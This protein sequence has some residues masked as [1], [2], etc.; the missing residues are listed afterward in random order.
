MEITPAE[1]AETSNIVHESINEAVEKALK[2]EREKEVPDSFFDMFL[3]QATRDKILIDYQHS[4]KSKWIKVKP[5]KGSVKECDY[6]EISF[7][8]DGQ[9]VAMIGAWSDKESD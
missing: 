7:T 4:E 2:E 8:P 6:I 1:L 9:R 3:V 5:N